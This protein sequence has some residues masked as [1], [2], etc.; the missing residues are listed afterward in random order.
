MLRVCLYARFSTE[1]QTESSI[2]DQLRICRLRVKREGWK[3]VSCHYDMAVSGSTA[4]G[5]RSGGAEMLNSALVGRFD[6]LILEGL[7]RLSRDLIEQ[8]QIVRRLEHR[9]IRIIGVSDG[10]DSRLAA[11]KVLRGVRGLI[12]ELYLDDLRHKTH[13]GQTGQIDRGYIAGGKSYGYDI[14]KKQHGSI[15][16][17][18]AEQAK[19]VQWIFKEYAEGASIQKIAHELNRLGIESPRNGGWAVSGLYGSPI[20]G[21]GILN[22]QLYVGTLIWNRSQWIKNPDTGARQR[23]E[24]PKEEWKVVQVPELRIIDDAVWQRVRDR[25]DHGRDATGRKKSGKKGV[26]LFGGMMTCPHC[27]GPM[28]AVNTRSYGCNT[29]KDK[30]KSVCQGF[31]IKRELVD[32]RLLAVLREDL[33]SVEAAEKFEKYFREAVYRLVQL[34]KKE[35]QHFIDRL[36]AID[37]DLTRVVDAITKVGISDVLAVRLK[38]LEAEKTAVVEHLQQQR[39]ETN[40]QLPNMKVLFKEALLRLNEVL[41][42]QP[43]KA[44]PILN[45]I[46]GKVEFSINEKNEAWAQIEAAQALN[47]AVE[48]FLKMVAGAGF[49][50]TTFGL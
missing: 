47:Y 35:E 1:K 12:N 49:E 19:W 39:K 44:R 40:V 45:A 5:S 30:G 10:Y 36:A 4:V 20:K 9:G 48:P 29:S 34:N 41:D 31:L 6:V 21:S 42:T 14:V 37:Q 17:I 7:D 38:N 46:F 13:R 15:Y 2:D 3:E 23:I 27:K 26:S 50:P 16:Q 24:R 18:N 43:E 11:R 28:I 22:N 33:L 25:I 32:G 8:E